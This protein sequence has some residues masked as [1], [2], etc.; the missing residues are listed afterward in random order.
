MFVSSR[1]HQNQHRTSTEARTQS[2]VAIDP[3]GL[4]LLLSTSIL[5]GSNHFHGLGDLLDVLDGLQPD[6]D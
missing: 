6:G 5:G 3:G 2:T 4:Q 1:L